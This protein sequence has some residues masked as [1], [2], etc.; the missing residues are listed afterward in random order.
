MVSVAK[1]NNREL[2][3]G[4]QIIYKENKNKSVNNQ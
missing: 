1:A 3:L 4:D 2:H